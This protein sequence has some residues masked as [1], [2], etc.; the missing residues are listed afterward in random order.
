MSSALVAGPCI[1]EFGWEICEWQGHVRKLAQGCDK[2]VICSSDGHLPLYA[3]MQPEFI[4]HCIA[5]QRDCH[6]MRAGSITNPG[7]LQRVQ[8][9]LNMAVVKLKS[10]NYTVTHI[11]PI[12]A[13]GKA[14]G[15]RRSIDQQLFV[16]YGDPS[17]VA[18]PYP[19]IIHARARPDLFNSTGDNY[20]KDL[21]EELLRLLAVE[22]FSK[23]AAIGLPAA[24]IVP[25]GA[26]DYRGIG[27][28]STMYLMAA[29]TIVVGPSSGPMHLA[30]MC[31]AP[32]MVW[33]TDRHQS[34]IMLRN[35]ERYEWYWN[36]LKT[37]VKVLLHK[38]HELLPP[39]Q[40]MAAVLELLA[41]QSASELVAEW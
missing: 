13:K 14:V 26:A 29:A 41:E 5:G 1:S 11:T 21:W 9:M 40:L 3:D 25:S 7:E 32:H 6:R 19:V 16:K 4:P 39:K 8:H 34:A 33:A 38:S 18:E 15:V 24:S 30:S 35:K 22:G 23:V 36:P 17:C 10:E 28:Q 2:V 31:G 20:P 27:L 12:P 37:P